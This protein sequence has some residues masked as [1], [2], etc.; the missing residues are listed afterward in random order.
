MKLALVSGDGLPVSGLLTIFR[1]VIDAELGSG[2]LELPVAADLGYSWRPDKEHFFPAGRPDSGYP[3]WMAVS[4]VVPVDLD[5]ADLMRRLTDIRAGVARADSLD[6]AERER[7]RHA[8]EELAVP[9]EEYFSRWFEENDIDW[10]CAVNMTLSDAVPVT[11]GLHRAAAKRWSDGR[12]GGVLFWDHDL[13]GSCAIFEDGVRVYPEAPNGFTLLPGSH[14]CHRWA[15]VSPALAKEAGG[16]PTRLTPVILPNV[17]PTVDGEGLQDRHTEFLAQ[18]GLDPAR[19]PLLVTV[20]MFRV[21]GVEI[22]V[23][24]LAEVKRLCQSRGTPVPYLLVFGSM[25]EDPPYAREVVALAREL[26]VM[27]DIVFLDGVPLASH[28]GPDGRWR[29][30]EVDLLRLC[31]AGSGAVLFTPNTPDVES[32]GLGPALAAVAGVPCAVTPYT[33]FEDFYG[34]RSSCVIVRGPGMADAAREL[35]ELMDRTA[36]GDPRV[37]RGLDQDRDHVLGSFDPQPWRAQFR[38]M[39]TD[40]APS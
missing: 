21:K 39:T 25:D 17:L 15:V 20:R 24:L 26:D 38:A 23:A 32:V 10:V 28:P 9:Y 27:D 11:V 4:D 31:R 19:P 2:Q 14:P 33:C 8:V 30:D 29:L 40:V 5:A 37:R 36:D 6:E 16:Y 22:S 13:F 18:R 1:N 34:P 35:L 12:A 7:L 3:E